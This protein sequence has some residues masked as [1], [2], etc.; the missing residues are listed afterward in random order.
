MQLSDAPLGRGL[1]YIARTGADVVRTGGVQA[2]FKGIAPS[3]IRAVPAAAATFVG[4]ELSKGELDVFRR[5]SY[6]LCLSAS[7]PAGD[8]DVSVGCER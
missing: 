2:L 7:S 3:V 5:T 6:P 8:E 4:F 1:G